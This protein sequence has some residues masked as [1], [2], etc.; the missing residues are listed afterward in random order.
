MA[1]RVNKMFGIG[2]LVF[3]IGD[4]CIADFVSSIQ[5]L[6]VVQMVSEKEEGP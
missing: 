1:S 5:F 4:D 2:D 3:S 6:P